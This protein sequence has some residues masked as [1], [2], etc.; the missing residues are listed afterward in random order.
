MDHSLISKMIHHGALV[1]IGL[2]LLAKGVRAA[3]P[4]TQGS[5]A[6]GA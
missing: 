6:A 1:I 4:G 3:I 2:V 5:R